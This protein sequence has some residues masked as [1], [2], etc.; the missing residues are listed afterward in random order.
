MD[1]IAGGK[2]GGDPGGLHFRLDA[3]GLPLALF[4]HG[5]ESRSRR[6]GEGW[7]IRLIVVDFFR[8]ARSSIGLEHRISNR[9]TRFFIQPIFFYLQRHSLSIAA[10]SVRSCAVLRG[11]V[12]QSLGR[13]KPRSQGSMNEIA[14]FVNLTS[15]NFQDEGHTST[16]KGS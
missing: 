10:H 9:Q 5:D 12:G 13:G 8:G 3:T 7:E 14:D 16:G 15:P 1:K 6:W 2:A 11:R 4:L